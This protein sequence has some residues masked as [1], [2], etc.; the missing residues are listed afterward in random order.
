MQALERHVG[1]AADLQSSV[2][3][4]GSASLRDRDVQGGE[5]FPR[6]RGEHEARVG[7]RYRPAAP[8]QQR[9]AELG[10]EPAYG[11]RQRWLGHLEPSRRSPKMQLVVD[12]QEVAELP[13]VDVDLVAT[14]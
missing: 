5:H 4:F 6:L 13:K 1:D 7:G 11:L 12:G 8:M 14:Q 2:L 10:L 9:H 3:G